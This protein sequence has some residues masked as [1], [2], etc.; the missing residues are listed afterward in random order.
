MSEEVQCTWDTVRV[1]ALKL[2]D[3][4]APPGSTS[5]SIAE[6]PKYLHAGTLVPAITW[7]S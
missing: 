7:V 1:Y 4:G 2:K 3:K 5:I 6:N